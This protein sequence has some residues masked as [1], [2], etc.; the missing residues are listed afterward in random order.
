MEFLCIAHKL[1]IKKKKLADREAEKKR[2][3]M[4]RSRKRRTGSRVSEGWKHG[5]LGPGPGV[6]RWL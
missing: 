2:R 3:R 4:A 6:Q 5:E 1:Q